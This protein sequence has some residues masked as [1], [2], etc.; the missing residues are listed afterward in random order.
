MSASF[1]SPPD[2]DFLIKRLK[3]PEKKVRLVLDTDTYNEVDDQFAVAYAALSPEKIS[4]EAIYAAPFYNDRSNSP[5]NGMQLSYEEINR[6]LS[7]LDNSSGIQVYQ[8]STSYLPG[9][10]EAVSSPAAED[11]IDRAMGSP[12]DEP[13]YVASIG[14]ITNIASALLLQPAIR[15]KI[16]VLWLGGNP[17]YWPSTDE[18]N[19][20]QDIAASRIILNSGVALVH[21]PCMGVVDHLTT[22]VAELEADVRG[23]SKIGDYLIDI[24]RGYSSS[25][26]AW[27]KVIW[28]IAPIAWLCN[29]PW[30]ETRLEH[31]PIL[32]DQLT[33]S[34]DTSRHLIRSAFYADRNPVF[35]DLFKKLNP[36]KRS[37][38]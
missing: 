34:R 10:F 26:F 33:W 31:S 29:H 27:S 36:Q 30:V 3:W 13:L 4:L 7:K 19:L 22:T 20:R 6:L 9:A 16:V 2:N 17:L 21:F 18:F 35:A 11:L 24:V 32:T 15:E 1:F 28:D 23:G 37:G 12:V 5:A 38:S 8:G 25:H 14:A